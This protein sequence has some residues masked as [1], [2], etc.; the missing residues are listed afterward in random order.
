M[1]LLL[2]LCIALQ[3]G[4]T[5]AQDCPQR[6]LVLE[7]Q[8]QIDSFPLLFPDCST[9]AGSLTIQEAKIGEI[10][11]L[12]ALDQINLIQGFF[13][14]TE[15]RSLENLD[16]LESIERIEGRLVLQSNQ[17]LSNMHALSSL[18]H[19]GESILFSDN[20]SLENF[21]AFTKLHKANAD[22]TITRNPLLRSLSGLDSL[23]EVVGGVLIN[24]NNAIT[25]LAG[26][27]Q[28]GKVGENLH[29]S[30]SPSLAELSG[31][32][33][34]RYIGA[35]LIIDNNSSLSSLRGINRLENIGGFLHLINC[36]S[37]VDLQG[38]S[39]LK[40][41]EGL[42]QIYN[43][44]SLTTLN[45]LDDIDHESIRDLAIIDCPKLNVCDVASICGYLRAAPSK[46]SIFENEQGCNDRDEILS[47][48]SEGGPTVFPGSRNYSFYP[49]PTFGRI[50]FSGDVG[51][52]SYTIRDVRGRVL[53]SA[54]FENLI[55]LSLMAP[56]VYSV[57]LEGEE[58]TII[59]PVVKL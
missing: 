33:S 54:P 56:G 55:D 19:V 23:R 59:G 7:R 42:L 37:L 12:T 15:N 17:S 45:G 8:S 28:L 21:P 44:P 35:D 16:G 5:A 3:F 50:R 30:E 52:A 36:Q 2:W 29:I 34:L 46:H 31:L 14:I 58:E 18:L 26:L 53:R 51:N 48:C 47:G 57:A 10:V 43:N 13:E 49:N 11:S 39:G 20:K 32:D 27:N 25:G 41:I 6:D 38:L 9:L 22:L 40:S 24:G 1:H 4:T